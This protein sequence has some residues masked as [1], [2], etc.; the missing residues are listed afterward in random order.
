MHG[1]IGEVTEPPR[2]RGSHTAR[3]ALGA[4]KS[5]KTP[6]SGTAVAPDL[7]ERLV[8]ASLMMLMDNCW[9]FRNMAQAENKEIPQMNNRLV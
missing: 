6:W 7:S 2:E 4:T 8:A 1:G 9:L 3:D 5:C